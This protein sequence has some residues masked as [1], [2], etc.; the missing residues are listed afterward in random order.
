M[1]P[2]GI[3]TLVLLVLFGCAPPD[4]TDGA[5]TAPTANLEN[6]YWKLTRIEGKPVTASEN[7]REPH[8]VLHPGEDRVAGSGGCNQFTGG[9]RIEDESLTFTQVAAT[10]MA[11]AAGMDTEQAFLAALDAVRRWAVTG[12]HL[13]LYDESGNILLEFDSVYLP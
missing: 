8:L 3:L 5:S 7:Q 10:R 6:T 11:C 1:H 13:A 9:Y 2:R 4:A 12:E